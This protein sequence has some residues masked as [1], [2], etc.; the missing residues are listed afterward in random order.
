MGRINS[1]DLN[2][3]VVVLVPGLPT[4][5]PNGYGYQPGIDTEYNRHAQVRTLRTAEKLQYGQE[6]ASAGYEVILRRRPDLVVTAACRIRW[7]GRELAVQ[8]V[9]PDEFNEYDLLTCFA[10]GLPTQH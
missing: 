4:K 5:D 8:G 9:T 3:R 6:A 10:S 1:G 2:Q 7:K